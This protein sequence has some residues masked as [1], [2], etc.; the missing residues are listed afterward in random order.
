MIRVEISYLWR[1]YSWITTE[2]FDK[3]FQMIKQ[4]QKKRFA[5]Y[6]LYSSITEL[7]IETGKHNFQ[8]AYLQIKTAAHGPTCISIKNGL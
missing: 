1:T 3:R 2:S 4:R 8:R 5:Y 7:E 6:R